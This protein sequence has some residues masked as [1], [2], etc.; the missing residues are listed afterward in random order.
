MSKTDNHQKCLGT[1][2]IILLILVFTEITVVL[3][4]ERW[5]NKP[6]QQLENVEK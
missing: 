3:S 2:A 6:A 1:L 5:L 4:Q